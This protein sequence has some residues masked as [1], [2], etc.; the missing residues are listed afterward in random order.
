[1]SRIFV[2]LCLAALLG[3]VAGS[4]AAQDEGAA[5]SE[6]AEPAVPT[7]EPLS[8]DEVQAL[9]TGNTENNQVMKRGVAT[10]RTFQA[11]Y[12]ADGSYKIQNKKGSIGTG[13]WFVDPLGRHCFRPDRKD[14]TKCDVIV[15]EGD[16]Y[17]RLRDGGRR[18]KFSI[19]KGNPG[20]L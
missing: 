18:G 7:G 13:V 17:I 2:S 3:I 12:A 4:V 15:P 5:A 1:M 9:F 6:A 14:K 8:S 20:G 16:E 11:Y 19:A 10:G